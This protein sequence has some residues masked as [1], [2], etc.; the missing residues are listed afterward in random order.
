MEAITR[1]EVI[2]KFT[3]IHKKYTLSYGYM[4]TTLPDDFSVLFIENNPDLQWTQ[5]YNHYASKY[6]L[7][8]SA[9]IY[10][11]IFGQKLPIRLE[12]PIEEDHHNEFEDY[13]R[14]G[15]HNDGFTTNRIIASFP[16]LFNADIDI[17]DILSS[18]GDDKIDETYAMNALLLL[19]CG[20]YVKYWK[21]FY[22]FNSWFESKNIVIGNGIGNG[23]GNG[24]SSDIVNQY[25]MEHYSTETSTAT[26]T[27]TETE[28]ETET[29]TA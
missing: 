26:A 20:G 25:I 5:T 1:A 27:A 11:S 7:V 28:T 24:K 17:V 18:S 29:T 4:V 16:T 14:F 13:F 12:R 6:V 2:Q 9:T 22:E 21:A 19:V 8:S 15:G 23:N 10:V 3:E